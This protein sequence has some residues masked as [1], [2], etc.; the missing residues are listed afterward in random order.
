MRSTQP[1][2]IN[3]ATATE[4]NEHT[5]LPT[6][7]RSRIAEGTAVYTADGIRFGTV[8]ECNSGYFVL[9][10]PMGLPADYFIPVSV[11]ARS[12]G[13]RADLDVSVAETLASGWDRGQ[14]IPG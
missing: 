2:R 1:K 9:P 4:R 8:T 6:S 10:E 5:M 12:S 14:A 11:V 13:A 3:S 7:G